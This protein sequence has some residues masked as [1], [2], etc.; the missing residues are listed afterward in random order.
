M[1]LK[2]A[3]VG[4]I[5]NN[6][7]QLSNALR[8]HAGVDA[9]LFLDHTDGRIARPESDDPSLV[10]NLPD[11]IHEGAWF[12]RSTKLTPWRSPLVSELAGFD[13]VVASGNGPV[14]AQFAPVPWCFFVTGGDLTVTPFP[15]RMGPV[16]ARTVRDATAMLALGLWQRRAIRR[17]D[18]IWMQDF[19]PFR[20]AVWRLRVDPDRL[21]ADYLPLVFDTE[22]FRAD[23]AARASGDPLVRQIVDGSDFVVFHPSRLII[24]ASAR[25][26]ETG[27]WKANDLLLE[28][29]A[30][31][32]RLGLA[33]HPVLVLPDRTESPDVEVAKGIIQRLGIIENVVWARPPRP[34]GFTRHEMIAIYS[35]ADVVA[36]DFGIGWFGAVALEGLSMGAPVLSHLD[37][38][39]MAGLYPWHPVLEAA[40][41]QAVARHLSRLCADPA[42]RAATGR[43][44]REWVER[45]H[46]AEAVAPRFAEA[47]T[48][49]VQRGRRAAPPFPPVRLRRRG[50]A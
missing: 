23:P 31:F 36:D 32:V 45:F 25:R 18:E 22:L 42:L 17:A 7:F 20:R 40:T 29:F 48:A 24:R 15:I 43:R 38:T 12:T 35:V 9:H 41:P 6:F 28:G 33:R 30:A 11:W 13:L 34:A 46:S 39:V 49:V 4:N 37:Q 19:T 3:F 47:M 44:G 16:Y 10:G 14:I 8:K 27:D 2:V 21:G 26:R 1:T 50:G 5:V